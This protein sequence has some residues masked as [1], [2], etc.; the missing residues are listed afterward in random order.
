MANRNKNKKRHKITPVRVKRI[1]AEASAPITSAGFRASGEVILDL[2]DILENLPMTINQ[3]NIKIVAR[4]EG[5]VV[6]V[7][8]YC[9]ETL[10]PS[11]ILSGEFEEILSQSEND[12]G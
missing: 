12:I 1:L 4:V 8:V 5:R 6:G 10:D 7:T 2:S 11:Q 9:E 3:D